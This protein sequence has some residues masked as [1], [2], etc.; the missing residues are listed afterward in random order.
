MS[1]NIR[2]VLPPNLKNTFLKNEVINDGKVYFT[3]KASLNP[4]Y[5]NNRVRIQ[6]GIELADSDLRQ[7]VNLKTINWI[8]LSNDPDFTASSTITITDFPYASNDSNPLHIVTGSNKNFIFNINPEAFFDPDNVPLE[9]SR[10]EEVGNDTFIINNWPLS[11]N[12]GLSTVYY[13]IQVQSESGEQGSFP[14][15]QG[16]Y[17]Q[18]FWQPESGTS[19]GK[20]SLITR[21][22]GFTGRKSLWR[23]DSANES[24]TG[25]Y[26]SGVSRY[27]CDI[28]ELRQQSV[29]D[30][31]GQYELISNRNLLNELKRSVLTE[32]I[33]T[34]GYEMYSY[35]YNP[36]TESYSN[37]ATI[38]V[39]STETETLSNSTG[40]AYYSTVPTTTA[41]HMPDVWAQA[42]VSIS[43]SEDEAYNYSVRLR[44]HPWEHDLAE[45]NVV[46]DE[47]EIKID[48]NN[49]DLNTYPIARLIRRLNGPSGTTLQT[50]K[51]PY[52]I[53][54]DLKNGALIELYFSDF[55]RPQ[56]VAI[57]TFFDTRRIVKAYLTPD[58][59]R[60]KSYLLA[61]AVVPKTDYGTEFSAA[62]VFESQTGEI[63]YSLEELAFG[64]GRFLLD[65]DA[66]DCK[67]DDILVDSLPTTNT[68]V[69]GWQTAISNGVW[70]EVSENNLATS[71]VNPSAGYYFLTQVPTSGRAYAEVFAYMPTFS[72]RCLIEFDFRPLNGE[73][74]VCLSPNPVLNSNLGPLIQTGPTPSPLDP[75][76]DRPMGTRCDSQNS[77]TDELINKPTVMISFDKA[78]NYI[79][80]IQRK[81][82]NSLSNK[83][84][85][86]Y[87]YVDSDTDGE[88]WKVF[89]S[90]ESP[91]SI[92]DGV[93][94]IIR[95]GTETVGTTRLEM[96][97]PSSRMGMGW[98]VSFGVRSQS[99]YDFRLGHTSASI[100]VVEPTPKIGSAY[101]RSVKIYG[102]P[103]K[104]QY[105]Q[106]DLDNQR[107][108][109]K[110]NAGSS[111]L[112]PLLGQQL[113]AAN[114]EFRDFVYES[115]VNSGY[116]YFAYKFTPTTKGT[117]VNVLP[118]LLELL[119]SNSNLQL[120]VNTLP[121]I[122]YIQLFTD[123]NGLID[124]PVFADWI[125]PHT[126][127]IYDEGQELPPYPS[128]GFKIN[129][130][131]LL[132]FV[133][134]NRDAPVLSVGN[135]YWLVVKLPYGLN[136]ARAK[137]SNAFSSY[138]YK[139]A[140]DNLL[141]NV[142]DG[143]EQTAWRAVPSLWFKLFHAYRERHENVWNGAAIYTRFIAESHALVTSQASGLSDT[144]I[145]DLTGPQYLSTQRPKIN[146]QLK[147]G[148]RT[149]MIG[150]EAADDISGIMAFRIGRETDFG[151]V[152]FSDW[153]Q[154]SAFSITSNVSYTIYHYGSWYQDFYGVSDPY[155]T[156]STASQNLGTD[157]PRKIWVQVVDNIGNI[158]ESYPITINAQ[159]MALVDT[160]APEPGIEIIDNS[161]NIIDFTNQSTV[162]L[163]ITANDLISSNIKD[164][165]FRLINGEGV[166][167]W[168]NF[169]QYN[170]VLTRSIVG[171]GSTS[172]L[173]GLK[174]I[175]IQVRDY[176]NNISQPTG[177]WD[178]ILPGTVVVDSETLPRN[179][180]INNSLTWTAPT[181]TLE[182]VYMTAIKTENYLDV[183][184]FDSFDSSYQSK[185]A[186]YGISNDE[187]T[188]SKKIFFANT[189]T[190]SIT[191]NGTPWTQV[192]SSAVPGSNRFI[193]DSAKGYVVFINTLPA[194][195]TFVCSI[196]RN[197]AQVWRWDRN[198]VQKITDVDIANER[199]ILSMLATSEY[200]LL[201]G[202]SGNL[203]AFD[204]VK[205][206]GPIFT[207]S[208][209][210]GSYLP[211]SCLT[212][213]KFQH[214]STEYVYVAT[215]KQS[216]I[217]RAPVSS[218]FS[219][220]ESVAKTA[221]PALIN[222]QDYDFTCATSA[223]DYIF[224]GTRQGKI[225]RYS[226]RLN[227]TNLTTETESL[228]EH[229]LKPSGIDIY[230][231]VALPVSDLVSV[232]NQVMAA[233]GDRPEIYSYSEHLREIPSSNNEHV[234]SFEYNDAWS[235]QIFDK[236]FIQDHSPWQFYN[237]GRTDTRGQ[238]S[239]SP[240]VVEDSKT[241]FGYK[242]GIAIAGI[243]AQNQNFTLESGSDWEQ[244]VVNETVYTVEFDMKWQSGT[245]SQGFE[246]NDNRYYLDVQL[247]QFAITLTSGTK[248]VTKNLI[249]YENIITPFELEDV[250]YPEQ[251][252]IKL[253]NFATVSTEDVN[254]L[255]PGSG[256]G[257]STMGWT[258]V[259]LCS[260]STSSE[261]ET[262]GTTT[263]TSNSLLINPEDSGTP[264]FAA[265]NFSPVLVDTH[266]YVYVKLKINPVTAYFPSNTKIMLA[267]SESGE[268]LEIVD[269]EWTEQYLTYS[270][271]YKTYLLKPAWNGTIRS[272]L[273]KIEDMPDGVSRP[274]VFIDYIA[275]LSESGNHKITTEFTPVRV[276]INN[277]SVKVW[278]GKYENPII[279]EDNFL[280]LGSSLLQL[281]FGKTVQNQ[282]ASTWAYSGFKYY[283]GEVVPPIA[284]DVKD[285]SISYRFNSAGGVRKLVEH[286]GAVWALTD[287]YYT[288]RL[289]DNPYDHAFK[290]WSYYPDA[291]VWKYEE[292]QTE[293]FSNGYGVIRPLA[294]V[295]Y[296][297]NLIV[298]GQRGI[299]N[300]QKTVPS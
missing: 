83:I 218:L 159:L 211:I 176:G 9:L 275:I 127:E 158:S 280:S 206:S 114:T 167:S 68:D 163:K 223:Y 143:D 255:N 89:I 33:S 178:N 135:N 41:T 234:S 129:N 295:S 101:L 155:T 277:R 166:G 203:W 162:N 93:R 298:S 198:S 87:K 287:G 71:I 117:E 147:P 244:A 250:L 248:T 288:K 177:A 293:K 262:I 67:S 184:L 164:M 20:P 241:E 290:A 281:R 286:Q 259:Q 24:A 153:Q 94:I 193:I 195:P 46:C 222:A 40:R 192:S 44:I 285:F 45:N 242:Y 72:D 97:L 170:E 95:R 228:Y 91:D 289:A 36:T 254:S 102:L 279:D 190:V 50:T 90:D 28:V 200:I 122:P 300:N 157:G 6:F 197:I 263:Q 98:Y 124:Q 221:M 270:S 11:A 60:T 169:Q 84:F 294:A 78:N 47:L 175:E 213:H 65:V 272:L 173:N 201:G 191:V 19:P 62:V 251:G 232:S 292:P 63:D 77:E 125:S 23:F 115:W 51:L 212:K 70:D 123:N 297:E 185:T 49:T 25:L 118:Q 107:H 5:D 13:K 205:I 283:I 126:E 243:S 43:G 61:S 69:T 186:Y 39:N 142:T 261:S 204:G 296:K 219:V 73:F 188:Y 80:I 145:V 146:L 264:I 246:I 22:E 8:K 12:G 31:V 225:F 160:T 48:F 210:S 119:V 148:V 256:T 156:N 17:D 99:A 111:Y 34:V 134:G 66:G 257:A 109:V 64:V 161:G 15:G 291:E 10:E 278:I 252:L 104:N 265:L 247:T 138:V 18:I 103:K 165:R 233:I 282:A 30:P 3:G 130:N 215:S 235:S 42:F 37:R 86:P 208:N 56:N 194:S 154:W 85:L 7:P 75:Y 236:E 245:G 29:N 76:N 274:N 139:D 226:R 140:S 27:L 131:T 113:L 88:S 230:E 172:Q 260:L 128:P 52:S 100:N 238:S 168:S 108:F 1:L 214:E 4:D 53:V 105:S 258:S 253:W 32:F 276:G 151:R 81:I 57:P 299:I 224:F 269:Y 182:K 181:E 273:I 266:S 110:S 249:S 136:L 112:K 59:D 132:Q 217:N 16:I 54:E 121:K 268:I 179:V 202:A 116:S 216:Y 207:A 21:A 240:V 92:G 229:V 26:G 237:N 149:T 141:E 267:W 199:V 220:W 271:E 239:I 144:A 180:L 96:P 284:R 38:S 137:F 133:L 187:D 152:V 55:V 58:S 79:S 35:L 74:Y 14:N 2:V 120:N 196:V 183:S 150:I 209:D 231:P 171:T 82:D 106:L 227:K 174:R 189:D